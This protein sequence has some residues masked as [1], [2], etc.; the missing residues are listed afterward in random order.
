M[1][2]EQLPAGLEASTMSMIQ[3]AR[4]RDLLFVH[5]VRDAATLA[6]EQ[7]QDVRLK[8]LE[9]PPPTESDS[10][11]MDVF[12][13]LALGPAAAPL[14]R[15]LSTRAVGFAVAKRQLS[16]ALDAA[17]LN[18]AIGLT[19]STTMADRFLARNDAVRDLWTG[20]AEQSLGVV[21]TQSQAHWPKQGAL[22]S[23]VPLEGDTASVAIRRAAY[24]HARVHELTAL[25]TYDNLVT[26]LQSGT[27]TP[28]AAKQLS[29]LLAK[30]IDKDRDD[31]AFEKG[32]SLLFEASIWVM[33]INDAVRAPRTQWRYLSIPAKFDKL[34]AYFIRR[35]P[36]DQ[37]NG[38]DNFLSHVIRT[39]SQRGGFLGVA[40]KPLAGQLGKYSVDEQARVD[41]L[42]WFEKL[43]AGHEVART[44]FQGIGYENLGPVKPK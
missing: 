1:N 31:Q 43:R 29:T 37:G 27:V 17:G 4:D 10:F 33:H 20:F 22:P 44:A 30:D 25:R 21:I 3:Q 26:G 13:S 28:E 34:F 15:A 11:L 19:E 40:A 38:N 12:I 35:F 14:V 7:V 6:G 9:N 16:T 18:V 39:S 8:L 36:H 23:P 2:G 32:L 41:L 42:I 24:A 5:T